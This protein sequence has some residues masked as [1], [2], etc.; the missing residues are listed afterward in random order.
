LSKEIYKIDG[1]L[2]ERAIDLCNTSY[3][4]E[5]VIS[6]QIKNSIKTNLYS[7]LFF[8]CYKRRTKK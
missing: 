8:Y 4:N 1:L 6:T 7:C 3:N 5:I 2:S